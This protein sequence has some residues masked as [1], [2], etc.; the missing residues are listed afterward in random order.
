MT[1]I[2]F[3]IV[4]HFFQIYVNLKKAFFTIFSF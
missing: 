4:V 1:E 3:R 2:A